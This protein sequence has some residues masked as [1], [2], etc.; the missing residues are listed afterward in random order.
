[1]A[2]PFDPLISSA[3]GGGSFSHWR[4]GRPLLVLR[5][6]TT[7]FQYARPTSDVA[8]GTWLNELGTGTAL[9]A[10][11]D[12]VSADDADWIQSAENPAS[13]T[14]KLGLGSISTPAA[15]DVTIRIRA[16]QI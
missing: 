11:V 1:M 13:D 5:P 10:S 14:V 3:S 7:A 12:E 2:A 15:G 4:G 16:Q 8:D 9:Y 6:P